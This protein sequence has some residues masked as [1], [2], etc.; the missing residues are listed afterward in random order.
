[1]ITLLLQKKKNARSIEIS[2]ASDAFDHGRG[3]RT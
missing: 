1:M 3:T 2:T